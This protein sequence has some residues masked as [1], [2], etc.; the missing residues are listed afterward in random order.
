MPYYVYPAPNGVDSKTPTALSTVPSQKASLE[1]SNNLSAG[2]AFFAAED[3]GKAIT[4]YKKAL[5]S[6]DTTVATQAE[7]KLKKA[8][9]EEGR[10]Q[11]RQDLSEGDALFAAED[12]ANAITAY[13]KALAS[14]DTTVATQAEKKLKKAL[15]EEGRTQHRQDLSEGD[16]LFAAEDY[17]NAITAY[18]KALASRDTTVATQAEKKLTKALLEE[19][20][21]QHR[22]DL[23]EG[24]ALFA[25]EDYA[26]AI[27][28][29]KKALA[30]RDTTVATQAEKKLTKALLEEG[31]TQHRQDLSEGDVLFA[32]EDYANAITAY[33]KALASRNTAISER[34]R[35]SLDL[36]FLEKNKESFGLRW[37]IPKW[38]RNY[39]LE[40]SIIGLFILFMWRNKVAKI[41][42]WRK[43]FK[44]AWKIKMMPQPSTEVPSEIFLQELFLGVNEIEKLGRIFEGKSFPIRFAGQGDSLDRFVFPLDF[45]E[46]L[47]P[48]Q[49]SLGSVDI[50]ASIGTLQKLLEYY[51]WKLEIRVYQNGQVAAKKTDAYAS[52]CWGPRIERMWHISSTGDKPPASIQEAGRI[53]A[54]EIFSK[55]WVKS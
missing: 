39:Y 5:A 23:S 11:H 13:K 28:A 37:F 17:A 30:S 55:G 1:K 16:A 9:L 42:L 19:G 40:F 10:T 29:Y 26:N 48:G 32:A 6:Q 38:S 44:S 27:T 34:A 12:Y 47:K 53:L 22:Q 8:L 7:K 14:R 41:F 49:I 21:T 35:K 46:V 18:K 51:S 20:R 25:A 15:L 33:K 45:A 2:D 43:P 24:D 50:G 3:Y 36:A 31:R 54:Y 52:L 4:A